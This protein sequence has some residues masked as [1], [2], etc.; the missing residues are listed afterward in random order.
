[1]AALLEGPYA[2]AQHN[3]NISKKA[4]LFFI[5]PTDGAKIKLTSKNSLASSLLAKNS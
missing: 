1:M 3:G 5:F 4:H 2:H